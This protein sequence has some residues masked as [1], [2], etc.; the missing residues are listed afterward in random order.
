[1][2]EKMML[3]PRSR[4]WTQLSAVALITIRESAASPYWRGA[5]GSALAAGAEAA[6]GRAATL[7]EVA[8]AGGTAGAGAV[9]TIGD[10]VVSLPSTGAGL[11]SLDATGGLLTATVAASACVGL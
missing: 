2:R 3:P 4:I 1:M 5:T 6:G 10:G 7:V 11:A 9:A 8:S